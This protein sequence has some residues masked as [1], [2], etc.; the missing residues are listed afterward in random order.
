MTTDGWSSCT[1]ESNMTI[2]SSHISDDWE[3]KNFVL[4]TRALPESHSAKHVT[5]VLLEAVEE[6]GLPTSHGN[7][8][9][10]TDKASNMVKAGEL[11]GLFTLGVV[12]IQSILQF[13]NAFQRGVSAICLPKSEELCLSF[14]GVIL[15]TTC[16][17]LRHE[18]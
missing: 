13:R 7:S 17:K 2:T 12:R 4:H 1:T 3:V 6:W 15:Q 11:L 16:L 14:I 9:L 10:V 8:P 5:E 18:L